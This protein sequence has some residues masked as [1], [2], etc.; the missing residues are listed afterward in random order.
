MFPTMRHNPMGQL[1]AP[2]FLDANKCV[3]ACAPGACWDRRYWPHFSCLIFIR[4][5]GPRNFE[6]LPDVVDV[7]YVT[8]AGTSS[9]SG[10]DV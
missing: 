10:S 8:L 3:R 9:A 2:I 5:T 6:E 4:P 7:K 1:A